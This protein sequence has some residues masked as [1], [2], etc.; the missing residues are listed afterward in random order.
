MVDAARRNERCTVQA[1]M[2]GYWFVEFS[3]EIEIRRA[4]T[5]LGLAVWFGC[6]TAGLDGTIVDFDAD[7]LRLAPTNTPVMGI[8]RESLSA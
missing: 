3:G 5:G 7:V 6:L 4:D 1:V 2:H 8:S